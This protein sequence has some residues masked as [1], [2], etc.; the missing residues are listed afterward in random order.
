[1]NPPHTSCQCPACN[2]ERVLASTL[3]APLKLLAAVI[4]LHGGEVEDAADAEADVAEAE[5][6]ADTGC[7]CRA[8]VAIRVLRASPRRLK[9]TA[10]AVALTADLWPTV[11]DLAA[12]ASSTPRTTRAKLRELETLGIL[13]SEVHRVNATTT[14][15]RYHVALPCLADASETGTVH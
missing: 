9:L 3:P 2:A 14:A 7:P 12:A 15:T 4:A 1:M 11:D 8:C 6:E 10:I 5:A 13:G